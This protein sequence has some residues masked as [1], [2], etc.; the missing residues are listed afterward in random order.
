[1]HT[2]TLYA[3]IMLLPSTTIHMQL[4]CLLQYT[5]IILL[6]LVRVSESC[7]L[8][9]AAKTRQRISEFQKIENMIGLY[10]II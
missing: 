10:P 9:E 7:V 4:E 8:S 6:S 1:M 2:A 5:Y 3:V